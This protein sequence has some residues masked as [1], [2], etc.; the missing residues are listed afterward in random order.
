MKQLVTHDKGNTFKVILGILADLDYHVKWKV[1]NA[2]DF[3][4][5]QKEKELL[6]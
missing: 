2:L 1:L 5:P 4:V 3:G 6:S